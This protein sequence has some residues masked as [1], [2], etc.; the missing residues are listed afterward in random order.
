VLRADG[1]PVQGGALQLTER[2]RGG[3]RGPDRLVGTFTPA[4]LAPGEYLLR[5]TV[6]DGASGAAQSSSIPFV[7]SG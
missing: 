5:I 4:G 6:T 2:Q 1:Q 3:G 7:V